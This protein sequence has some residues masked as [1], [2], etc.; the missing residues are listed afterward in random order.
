MSASEHSTLIMVVVFLAVFVLLVASIPAAIF[1]N[2]VSYTPTTYVEVTPPSPF[3]DPAEIGK[4]NVKSQDYKYITFGTGKYWALTYASLNDTLIYVGW[5]VSPDD[6]IV[7]HVHAWW[8]YRNM[9]P[10][11]LEK[12]Y[13]L[14]REENDISAFY[15]RCITGDIPEVYVQISYDNISYSS[16]LEAWNY[17]EIYVWMGLLENA[18]R[19]EA[20]YD[21]WT[22]LGQLMSFQA[23]NIHPLLNALIA[24]PLWICIIVSIVYVFDKILPF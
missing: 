14:A 4:G 5:D 18:T 23:P 20:S 22:L 12:D 2:Q 7:K 1:I 11:P 19:Q 8:D 10:Y 24:I 16:L 6:L 3:W 17:G 21:V 15:M 9:L 13:V